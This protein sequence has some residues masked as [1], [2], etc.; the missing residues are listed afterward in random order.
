LGAGFSKAITKNIMPSLDK[1]SEN[2]AINNYFINDPVFQRVLFI[3]EKNVESWLTYLSQDI[4]WLP[5]SMQYENKALFIKIVNYIK[6]HFE[7][8][9]VEARK[10]PIDYV[11]PLFDYWI[12][13]NSAV[14]TMNYDTLVEEIYKAWYNRSF[15]DLYPVNIIDL[16]Y[17][18]RSKDALRYKENC[19]LFK[20]H[21]S[22]NWFYSG[23]DNFYGES[24]YFHDYE[25]SN[26]LLSQDEED[27]ARLKGGKEVLIIPPVIDKSSYYQNEI[28]KDLWTKAFLELYKSNRIYCIGYSFPTIDSLFKLFLLDSQARSL[29][30]NEKNEF[31]FINPDKKK[32]QEN[33]EEDLSRVFNIRYIENENWLPELYKELGVKAALPNYTSV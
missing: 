29:S 22:I 6:K 7:Q 26:T 27:F 28:L 19:K 2:I 25:L 13:Q 21:G 18:L 8:L 11:A 23:K 4:P 3:S 16:K 1:L 20:L 9:Q 17:F 12:K 24:I 10:G 14:V 31:V 30:D 32:F 15:G 5:K 33:H